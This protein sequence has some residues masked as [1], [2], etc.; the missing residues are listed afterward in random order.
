MFA[1]NTV[2]LLSILLAFIGGTQFTTLT[3]DT[4]IKQNESKPPNCQA[5]SSETDNKQDNLPV[6]YQQHTTK[7]HQHDDYKNVVGKTN[8]PG[9]TTEST[10]SVT[11]ITAGIQNSS[12]FKGWLN[13]NIEKNPGFNI[14]S[15]MQQGFD[16]EVRDSNW[17]E[18]EEIKVSDLFFESEYLDGL[19]LRD[20]ECRETQCRLSIA[21][22][23][24]DQANS[25]V[26]NLLNSFVSQEDFRQI[27]AAPNLEENVTTLYVSRDGGGLSFNQ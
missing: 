3:Q 25:T 16:Q 6:S 4:P 13:E 12:E 11:P 1:R 27:V 26:D 17:A 24:L 8:G 20:I 2:F 10:N 23:N 18:T 14:G 21:V 22:N 15:A 9:A 5:A 7:E 19:A